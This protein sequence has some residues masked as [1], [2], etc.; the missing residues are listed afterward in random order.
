MDIR[1]S[2]ILELYEIIPEYWKVLHN[3][4]FMSANSI[5]DVKKFQKSGI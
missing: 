3:N 1:V 2:N 5:K 4:D